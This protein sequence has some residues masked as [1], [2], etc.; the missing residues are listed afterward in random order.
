MIYLPY[1][2]PLYVDYLAYFNKNHDFFECHE[3]LEEYWKDIAPGDKNHV[4]VGLVQLATGMYHWRRANQKGA[5]RILQKA[6]GN[7]L[8]NQQSALLSVLDIEDLLQQLHTV[9]VRIENGEPF[10]PFPIIIVDAQLAKKVAVRCETVP[11]HDLHYLHNKHML[12][13]RSEVLEAR[14]LKIASRNQ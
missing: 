6:E 5:M 10:Q 12:R 9:V 14:A 4:L 13:D 1:L 11:T 8:Q 2:H 3:V 7:L